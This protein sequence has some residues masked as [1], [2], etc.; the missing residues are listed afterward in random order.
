MVKEIVM[1]GIIVLVCVER[2]FMNFK[3]SKVKLSNKV[4]FFFLNI[5]RKK[6]CVGTCTTQNGTIH[7]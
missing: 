3:A 7:H 6:L 1:N 2:L 5:I 4:C